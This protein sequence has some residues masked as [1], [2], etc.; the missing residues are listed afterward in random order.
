[1]SDVHARRRNNDRDSVAR[2]RLRSHGARSSAARRI[3]DFPR[4]VRGHDYQKEIVD[5]F[6][7]LDASV[8]ALLAERGIGLTHVQGRTSG[9]LRMEW[10]VLSYMAGAWLRWGADDSQVQYGDGAVVRVPPGEMVLS[11]YTVARAIARRLG[12]ADVPALYEQVRAAAGR[13]TSAGLIERLGPARPDMNGKAADCLGQ[14]W[15]LEVDALKLA[16]TEPDRQAPALT[17]MMAVRLRSDSAVLP[18]A[19]SQSGAAPLAIALVQKYPVASIAEAH[20]HDRMISELRFA[21]TRCN[22]FTSSPRSA[23][24]LSWQ[25]SHARRSSIGAGKHLTVGAFQEKSATHHARGRE[26]CTMPFLIADIDGANSAAT[27]ALALKLLER[28]VT[29]GVP[30]TDLVVAYTGHRGFHVRIPH[31]LIG[32]PVYRDAVAAR[33]I[34]SAFFDRICDGLHDVRNAI[35]STLCSPLSQI[36]AIG[37]L[38]EKRLEETGVRTYCVGYKGDEFVDLPLHVIEQYALFYSPFRLHEPGAVARVATLTAMFEGIIREVEN[39]PSTSA[40]NRGIISRIKQADIREGEEFAP[41][42]VGRSKAAFLYALYLQTHEAM[43]F[44]AALERLVDWNSQLPW[45]LPSSE[46]RSAVRSAQ[47]QSDR[48]PIQHGS[49]RKTDA[50][51]RS[52]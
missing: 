25:Q 15:S 52:I 6:V 14:R 13:L 49:R 35:D 38:H 10:L 31:G 29:L 30:L 48:P 20:V 39:H 7:T 9:S 47:R 40:Q 8:L 41:D 46:L 43:P 22:S 11:I 51:K 17:A 1:M 26:R 23:D 45:P 16:D 3:H 18:G 12:R 24:F 2:K 4:H 32:T 50:T 42:H 37:S 28:L 19:R 21:A 5:R 34:V 36:R 44:D 27:H 33:L